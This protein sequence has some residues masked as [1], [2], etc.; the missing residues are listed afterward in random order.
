LPYEATGVVEFNWWNKAM[1][2][3][4]VKITPI[5]KPH[6]FEPHPTDLSKWVQNELLYSMYK[7]S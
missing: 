1:L 6:T 4:L 5:Q 7:E 2:S 3:G